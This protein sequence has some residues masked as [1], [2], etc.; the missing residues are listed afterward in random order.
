[1]TGSTAVT[2]A[3]GVPEVLLLDA[4][5]PQVPPLVLA[6]VAEQA[7]A[8]AEQAL[9]ELE[10][11]PNAAHLGR[12]RS[13]LRTLARSGLQAQRCARVLGG[14][15]LPVREFIALDRAVNSALTGLSRRHG[16]APVR[17]HDLHAVSVWMDP[18]VLE[19]L[20]E[21][22]LDW[23]LECGH[24]VDVRMAFGSEP[25][26]PDLILTVHGVQGR[27]QPNAPGDESPPDTVRWQLLR[28]LAQS[29]ALEPQRIMEGD[30]VNLV[31]PFPPAVDA[32]PGAPGVTGQAAP[33]LAPGAV[34]GGCHVVVV[35]HDDNLRMLMR[36]LLHD[37]GVNVEV[38]GS[39]RQAEDL[40]RHFLAEAVV[41]G[42]PPQDP[43][44]L[45]LIGVLRERNPSVRVIQL[46]DEDYLYI[47]ADGATEAARVG[48]SSVRQA[49]VQAV[50]LSVGVFA[51]P[52]MGPRP[53]AAR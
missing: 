39:P 29:Q 35:E 25:L 30:S 34:G 51:P 17:A 53:P 40:S 41:N 27:A 10:G 46:T 49:L 28:L 1:M 12:A 14:D 32:R 23:A 5:L 44:V 19:L 36:E 43:D 6:S 33:H 45:A 48:R 38:F 47:G 52:T 31:L 13:L 9:G 37:A 22:A 2:P 24:S 11:R 15:Y 8:L 3:P 50:L 7:S 18:P 21:L 20:L 42:Y 26:H 4:R 16:P